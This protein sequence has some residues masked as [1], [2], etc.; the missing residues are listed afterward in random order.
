MTYMCIGTLCHTCVYRHV[1]CV[2][3]RFHMCT[4]C[5]GGLHALCEVAVE[6]SDA[7]W[8]RPTGCLIFTG[9]FPQ[10]SPIGIHDM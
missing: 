9:P 2:S 10:E 6:V 5:G 4:V 1:H 8:R 3:S 7:G